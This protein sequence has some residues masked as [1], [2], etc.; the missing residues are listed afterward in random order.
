MNRRS[1]VVAGLASAASCGSKGSSSRPRI[2]ASTPPYVTTFPVYVAREAGYFES[3]GL[4]VELQEYPSSA[5]TTALLA[6]NQVHVAFNAFHPSHINLIARGADIRYVAGR[7][8]ARRQCPDRMVLYGR[9]EVFP[10]GFSDL[11]RLAGRRF[12][13]T[14]KANIGEF[15]IDAMLQSVGLST[16][17]MEVSYLREAD[18]A[19]ALLN[20]QLDAMIGTQSQHLAGFASAIVRGP[21]LADILP[22]FQFSF[23]LFGAKLLRGD[24]ELGISFLLAYLKGARDYLTGASAQFVDAFAAARNLD[25]DSIRQAC[26]QTFAR[27]GRLNLDSFHRFVAWGIKKGYCDPEAAHVEPYETRFIEE[28]ARRLE[29]AG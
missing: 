18:A 19:A 6:G 4:D 9:S 3:A 5:T 11:K 1:F 12:S 7:E 26:R 20:G 22:G 2:I 28:A 25:P 24:P 27:D 14:R 15:T 10:D 29:E 17:N 16:A 23:A 8:I 13:V 21:S